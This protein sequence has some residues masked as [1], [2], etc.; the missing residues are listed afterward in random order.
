MSSR[1]DGLTLESSPAENDTRTTGRRKGLW[2]H[3]ERGYGWG[4]SCK[5]GGNDW[6]WVGFEDGHGVK[7]RKCG[8]WE[9]D[10][11]RG[12]RTLIVNCDGQ[13]IGLPWT[14]LTAVEAALLATALAETQ[15]ALGLGPHS[16]PEPPVFPVRVRPPRPGR[17]ARR[18]Q[19][20]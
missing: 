12:S 11:M 6:E 15:A 14:T 19:N 16:E 13:M 5:C 4:G 9:R 3:Y 17:P 18:R 2:G 7:C 20:G 8:W 10:L 1:P